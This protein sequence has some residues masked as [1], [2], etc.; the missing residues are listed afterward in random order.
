MSQINKYTRTFT[1]IGIVGSIIGYAFLLFRSYT[2]DEE[3]SIKKI[4]IEILNLE[5]SAKK[6]SL[7]KIQSKYLQTN[8][9]FK[10][11]LY[12][13]NKVNLPSNMKII[14]K[15]DSANILMDKIRA[16]HPLDTNISVSYYSKTEEAEK[17][18]LSLKSLTYNLITKN[19][20]ELMRS[21]KTNSVW[22][23]N[24]VDISDVK[25]IALALIRAGIP[26]RAIRPF[27]NSSSNYKPN[28]VEIGGDVRVKNSSIQPYTIKE[29][30]TKTKFERNIE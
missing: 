27:R 24:K 4:R 10:Y 12:I 3:I 23:G 28:I 16:E 8:L 17:I 29:I 2:L 13:E 15:S 18:T 9:K 5:I 21:Y 11:G 7:D 26:I 20:N 22:F 25:I 1:L 30:D 14:Q 19:P 6:D